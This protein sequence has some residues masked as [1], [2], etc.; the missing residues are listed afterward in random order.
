M[1]SLIS[2]VIPV[3]NCEKYLARCLDSVISQTYKELEIIV[4]DDGSPDN[5]PDICDEYA[6]KDGRIK[7]IHKS[8]GGASSAR[9]AGLAIATGEFV[10]FV[11]SDDFLPEDSI[12][13][14]HN[15]ITESESQYAS[16]ICG[17]VNAQSRETNKEIIEFSKNPSG[18]LNVLSGNNAYSPYAKIYR[19]DIFNKNNIRYD[20]E[21][22]CSEDALMIRQ[23]LKYC[24]R[25]CLI[26]DVVYHY[27]YD[28]DASLS[29]KGYQ[30]Y[31]S[32]FIKKLNAL[33]E[34]VNILPITKEE[35]QVFITERAIHGL[36]VGINH[37]MLNWNNPK[38]QKTLICEGVELLMPYL[39]LATPDKNFYL[40][41]W[42]NSNKIY[43]IENDL[44]KFFKKQ[45]TQ[46][47]ILSFIRTV[48][49]KIKSI[50]KR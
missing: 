9:N 6:L 47:I 4:C 43:I 50:L 3:Y 36:K 10:C 12:E 41:K 42:W 22:K 20:E 49:R 34:L 5:C 1:S 21:L 35:K 14:L 18:L 30:G 31:V 27:N 39:F 29:K 26:S 45:R 7:V 40:Y 13:K 37:Y 33:D 17:S 16:G 23:Y 24:T 19:L 32:Y 15:A 2:V 25:I 38:E 8:N 44:E 46:H 48:K 28:N 11:D